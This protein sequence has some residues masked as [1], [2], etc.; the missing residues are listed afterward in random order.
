MQAWQPFRNAQV[1]P[2]RRPSQ[3][4]A[5]GVQGQTMVYTRW[6]GGD[7]RTELQ[8]ASIKL[9]GSK[10][11]KVDETA[12]E[13]S[14]SAARAQGWAI[15][16]I[17]AE[18]TER[19]KVLSEQ[20]ILSLFVISNEESLSNIAK[21]Y[22]N[23]RREVETVK[24]HREGWPQREPACRRRRTKHTARLGSELLKWLHR[25]RVVSI[26]PWKDHVLHNADPEHP[27]PEVEL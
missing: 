13:I 23:L 27:G 2:K 20:A 25:E 19:P 18:N 17:S 11:A 1:M 16:N 24:L 7:F 10:A 12:A 14:E 3:A 22:V 5:S 8:Q 21:E 6:C 26:L 4:Q 9:Q 15:K